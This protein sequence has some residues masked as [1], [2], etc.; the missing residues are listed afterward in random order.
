VALRDPVVVTARDAVAI[1]KEAGVDSAS[2]TGAHEPAVTTLR[3]GGIHVDRSN[4]LRIRCGLWL[5]RWKS[6]EEDLKKTRHFRE[7]PG[8]C[9][10]SE[11]SPVDCR[12]DVVEEI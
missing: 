4:V 9:L 2:V 8:N 7:I 5:A 6:H 3:F 12:P 11:E 10:F 1:E